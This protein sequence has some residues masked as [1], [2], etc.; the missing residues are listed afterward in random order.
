MRT[1]LAWLA[2]LLVCWQ[3]AASVV[4]VGLELGGRPFEQHVRVLRASP[5]ELIRAKLGADAGIWEALK[6]R[7]PP[8]ARVL[9]SFAN[10]RADYLE[11]KRRLT[12]LGSL[13]YPVVLE[14]WRFDPGRAVAVPGKAAQEAYVLDLESGRDFSVWPHEELARGS[15]F[16][17]LLVGSRAR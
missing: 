14:G 12:W 16:R 5:D 7:V 10:V 15:N 2:V 4:D 9:V 11:L 8:G 3:A 6:S 1:A 13:V 17:L